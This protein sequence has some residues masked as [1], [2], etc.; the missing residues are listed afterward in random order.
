[1][2]TYDGSYTPSDGTI[3]VVHTVFATCLTLQSYAWR[4]VMGSSAQTLMGYTEVSYDYTDNEVAADMVEDLRTGRGYVQAWYL[5]NASQSSLY[6][7]WA[8]YA[9]EGGDVVEYSAR[10]AVAP[11]GVQA[12]GLPAIAIEST[13]TVRALPVLLEDTRRF[14]LERGATWSNA[15]AVPQARALKPGGWSLLTDG[16]STAKHARDRA[17]EFLAAQLGELPD[18]AELDAVVPIL[19]R[20]GDGDARVAG[21]HVRFRRVLGG[22]PVRGNGVADHL[23]VLVAG[24]GVVAW[25]I[26][27]PQRRTERVVEPG[28]DVA[29]ALRALGPSLARAA[30]GPLRLLGA[31]PV[32]GVVRDTELLV[33]AFGFVTDS[34]QHVVVDARTGVLL[35]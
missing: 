30:K 29:S 3:N 5:S 20:R 1:V 2:L 17:V 10:A 9:R 16:A 21:Y 22:L 23:S 13:G 8:A 4:S 35:R 15:A 12:L 24:R 11:A 34:G 33:P 28:L 26:A 25:T 19:T 27:W 18:D 32:W 7:R 14:P 6:D 31:S